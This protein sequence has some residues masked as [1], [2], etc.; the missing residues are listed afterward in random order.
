MIAAIDLRHN[1]ASV[2]LEW[3]GTPFFPRMAK[4]YIGADCVELALAIYKEAGLVPEDVR[5]PHYH[6]GNAA[7]LKASQVITWLE[8]APWFEQEPV[9]SI[10]SLITF[11]IGSVEHHVGVV[12]GDRSFVH[13]VR[14]YGVILSDLQDATWRHRQRSSWGPKLWVSEAPKT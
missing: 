1:I 3:V 14:G 5:L 13:S 4:K 12:S 11:Q 10:G 9:A 6:V 2:A 7:H 8:E